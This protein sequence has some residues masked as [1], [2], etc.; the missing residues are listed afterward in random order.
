MGPIIVA[1]TCV[2]VLVGLL[3]ALDPSM[4]T[5]TSRDDLQAKQNA[6]YWTAAELRQAKV[7]TWRQCAARRKLGLGCHPVAEKGKRR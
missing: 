3:H 2:G 7:A 6:A 4:P 5:E 1:G